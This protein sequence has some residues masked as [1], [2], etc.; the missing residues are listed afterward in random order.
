MWKK[1]VWIAVVSVGRPTIPFTLVHIE[2]TRYSRVEPDFDNLVSSF[3]WIVDGL[4]DAKVIVSDKPSI[5]GQST[6]RW[7]KSAPKKVWLKLK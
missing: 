1:A 4:I 7:K 2:L 6:Y 5:I 3:K